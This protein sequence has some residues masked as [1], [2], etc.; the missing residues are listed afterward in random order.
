V[1]LQKGSPLHGSL[2]ESFL[3]KAI[4]DE[5]ALSIVRTLPCVFSICQKRMGPTPDILYWYIT[6]MYE[7]LGTF[8]WNLENVPSRRTAYSRKVRHCSTTIAVLQ[9]LDRARNWSFVSRSLLRHGNCPL[10]LYMILSHRWCWVAL[11]RP[12]AWFI[13][14]QGSLEHYMI[15]SSRSSTG[16][17][18]TSYHHLERWRSRSKRLV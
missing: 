14:I 2:E 1:S 16:T 6:C 4:F 10:L 5:L 13:P 9:Y 3:D 8:S 12:T 15:Y 18:R 7:A 11:Y 17:N